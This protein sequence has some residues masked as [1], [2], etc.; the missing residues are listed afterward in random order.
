MIHYVFSGEME[1]GLIV[2][3]IENFPAQQTLRV[4]GEVERIEDWMEQR[5]SVAEWVRWE[6]QPWKDQ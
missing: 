2:S 1:W 3:A 6:A 5:V 4:R